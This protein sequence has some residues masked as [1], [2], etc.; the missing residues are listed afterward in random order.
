MS[1]AEKSK[2]R[3]SGSYEIAIEHE[4]E[5]SPL[6]A[7]GTNPNVNTSSAEQEAYPKVASSHP[8]QSQLSGL[9]GGMAESQ[10]TAEV[11]TKRPH[12]EIGITNEILRLKLNSGA[13]ND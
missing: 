6:G 2:D 10:H 3:I 12:E 11:N 9:E 7:T 1:S 13:A 4:T 5:Y 8:L